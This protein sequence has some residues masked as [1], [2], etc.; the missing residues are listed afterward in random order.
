MIGQRFGHYRILE[1]IGAG[2]MGEV[3]R[4]HDE[5]LDR[6]V[7]LKVLPTSTLADETARARLLREARAAAALN[8]PYICTIHEVGEAEGQAY[9]AMEYLV[10]QPLSQVIPRGGLTVELVLRYGGQIADALEHA[11]ERGI[12]HRD[13]K[14][15]NVLISPGG[16]AK[17]LDFGLAK[18]VSSKELTE[19][20]TQSQASLTQM[21][22]FAG[23]L[24]YMSPE[25]LRGQSASAASD[26]WA[27]GVVLYEMAAGQRPFQG[28][29]GFELSSAILNQPPSPLPGQVPTELKAVIERCLEKEPAR[30]YQRAGE[31]RAALEAIQTG[32]V[33]PWVAWRYRLARRPRL[34]LAATVVVVLAV[35]A[36]LD[37]GGLRTRLL[38]EAAPQI[39]SLAVLPLENLSGDPGQEYFAD[40]MTEA[41][42]TDLARLGGLK[43][44]I[45]RGSVMRYKGTNKSLPEIAREL[46]VDALI[47]GAVL[48]GGDRL[49]ITAQLINPT[50]GAQLWAD[51]YDRDLRNVIYLQNEIVAAITREI[52]LQLTPQEQA[53]LATARTVEPEAYEAYLKGR[54]HWLKLTPKALDT[55]LEYFQLAANKDP[56][57]ALAYVGISGAWAARAH[58]GWM[59]HREA[60]PHWK[61]AA[62]KAVELDETLSEA[63][64]MLATVKFYAEWDWAAGQREFQ[65]AIELNP[66][67]TD[68]RVMYYCSLWALNRLEEAMA[69]IRR[70]LESDPL[71]PLD[72]TNLGWTLV[73]L[74]RYDDAI[75]QFQ[76]VLRIEPGLPGAHQNLWIGFHKEQMF[77]QALTEAKNYFAALSDGEVVEA[78]ERGYAQGG[79]PGAMR[80]AAETLAARSKRTY[81]Q[82][83]VIASAYALAGEK[84]R[85]L[86]WLEK[87][88]LERDSQLVYLRVVPEL[89]PLRNDPRFQDLLRRMNLPQ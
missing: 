61:A 33:A 25:Q 37:V 76:E 86:D 36:A 60:I 30:R 73:L 48:R 11:H 12:V 49:R 1:K 66:R 68:W 42:I 40:G 88:Y 32:A 62:E 79:Y 43:R 26:V 5:Q 55:A 14:S 84:D 10:G 78:I 45:A 13:L 22:A 81:V 23:T 74:G 8:H 75:A 6:D 82:P 56:N 3:Y 80:E 83:T 58:M 34:V 41:L 15:A 70:C 27:L 39:Q 31:V 20:T 46:K 28:Q 21:G 29:T 65:R 67:C 52:R 54:F 18:R 51:R 89:D 2:G 44:V 35:L 69:E 59:P 47:T 16:R 64:E 7:A 87:A 50:T 71:N 85:A 17:V 77:E 38:G 9:I 63:H 57:Y 53:R 24:P 19:A 4:A 72:R